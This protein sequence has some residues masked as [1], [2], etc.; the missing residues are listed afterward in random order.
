MTVEQEPGK[1][2]RPVGL[3][4]S[5]DAKVAPAVRAMAAWTWRLLL[6]GGGIVAAGYL[7]KRFEDV[8]FPIALALLLSAFLLGPVEWAV[9]KG[10]PRVLAVLLAI[11][12]TILALLALVGF[13]IQQAI[14]GG[15]DLVSQFLHTMDQTREWLATG[16]LHIDSDM[17]RAGLNDLTGW[18]KAHEGKLASGAIGTA[19]FGGR[20]GTGI[21]LT[22]FLMI[23]FLYDGRNMWT[24]FT[25][26]VPT[27]S[28]EWVRGAG[29]AGFGT[30]ESYVRATVIV[31]A[32][33]ATCIGIGLA[34]LGVPM[35]LP[36]VAIIFLGSFIPIVGSF[37]AGT[38]AVFVALT[39]QGWVHAVIVLCL[40]VL[41]M[42]VE[43]HVLQPFLL[44]Y[45]VKLHPVVV[46]L[47][48]A[49]GI[50]LAGIVG[51]L[52]AVPFVAFLVTAFRWRPGQV[53]PPHKESK[54][55]AWLRHTFSR[56]HIVSAPAPAVSA[57]EA[58]GDA[59]VTPTPSD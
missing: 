14:S 3:R 58:A 57:A 49:V 9:R 27:G 40:L 28:R 26:V 34:I 48:I 47:S 53:P 38:L 13:V 23:F 46:I 4:E 31:A 21:L 59:A 24:T 42:A 8:L 39:T 17:L 52:L 36:L 11:F 2:S 35:V 1:E 55:T 32:I 56:H 30:L 37:A 20:I 22:V 43:G 12:L 19:A 15:P 41:V 25:K 10:V 45:S 29:T 54:L 44:G 16:P 7:F 50:M 33:D 18:V 5:D 51:G 6:I